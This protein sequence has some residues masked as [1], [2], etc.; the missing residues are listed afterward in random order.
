MA[1]TD[2]VKSTKVTIARGDG[3]NPEVFTTM[4]GLTTKGFQQTRATNDV[5]DWDCADADAAPIIVRDAGATDWSITGSGLLHRPL[6][7]LV[8]A[9]YDSTDPTNYRF[10]FDDG[11][12]SGEP[13][14][15]YYE[16]PAFITDLTIGAANG[17]FV[18]ISITLS[19]AGAKSFVSTS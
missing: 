18:N 2:K 1:Y 7:E 10:V 4:C 8:Q 12:D 19:A 3:E 5:T 6:L 14:D 17:E 13:I 15:G 11:A 16:G 9:D